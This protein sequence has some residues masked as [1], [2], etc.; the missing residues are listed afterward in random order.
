MFPDW[1]KNSREKKR[2]CYVLRLYK[3]TGGKSE[4]TRNADSANAEVML[5]ASYLPIPGA[6]EKHKWNGCIW[7]V[8]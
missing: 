6:G 5:K 4:G 3:G 7:M 1:T 8:A 2:E